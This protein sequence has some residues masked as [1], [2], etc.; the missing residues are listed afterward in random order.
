VAV[1]LLDDEPLL[2][3]DL[4]IPRW[5]PWHADAMLEGTV[6]PVVGSSVS[7]VVGGVSRAGTVKR[8]GAPYGQVRCRIVGGAGKLG[9]LCQ[10]KDYGQV[11][12]MAVG[13]DILDQVG[14]TVGDLSPLSA[15]VLPQWQLL[16]ETAGEALQRVFRQAPGLDLWCERSGALS[17]RQTTWT[18]SVG[19]LWRGILPQER[20]A[21]LFADSGEIEPGVRVT[22]L[23]G[24]FDIE[25]A[26]YVLDPNDERSAL[27][28]SIWYR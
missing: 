1:A 2:K 5:G 6:A 22:T 25:R 19:A 10:P 14:E 4:M 15:V 7:L 27:R 12:A 11:T 28:L 20:G 17:A 18:R 3:L 9:A 21:V 24:D 23:H 8:S 26:Q 13:R 16:Q